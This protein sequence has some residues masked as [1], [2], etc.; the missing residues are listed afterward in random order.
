[1]PFSSTHYEL[2]HNFSRNGDWTSRFV[3]SWVFSHTLLVSWNNTGLLPVSGDLPT[4][5]GLLLDDWEGSC[6]N[7]CY[8]LSTLGWIPSALV[9]FGAFQLIQYRSMQEAWGVVTQ[10]VRNT[11][12]R[13]VLCMYEFMDVLTGQ[14]VNVSRGYIKGFVLWQRWNHWALNFHVCYK[15]CLGS[16][17]RDVFL[18]ALTAG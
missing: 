1:M 5:P 13:T 11:R 2:L 8:L 16:V 12:L 7:I 17:K 3:F 18:M 14:L 4:L 6:C 9:D 15:E 10:T